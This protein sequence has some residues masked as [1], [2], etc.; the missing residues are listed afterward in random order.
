MVAAIRALIGPSTQFGT[1]E[2]LSA[3]V[4][5]HA[6][7]DSVQSALQQAT[8][9][10]GLHVS[11][12]ASLMQLATQRPAQQPAPAATAA[13]TATTMLTTVQVHT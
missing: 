3:S 11:P 12:G 10:A 6:T 4:L 7:L 2:P 8:G 5:R 13:P 9:N 1:A